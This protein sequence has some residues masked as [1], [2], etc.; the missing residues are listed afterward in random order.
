MDILVL[1]PDTPFEAVKDY[2]LVELRYDL[3]QKEEW[4]TLS[5]RIREINPN[6][7]QIATIRYTTDGG[8]FPITG[9]R[10]KIWNKIFSQKSV[11]EIMDLEFEKID[12]LPMI[13]E[14]WPKVDVIVSKHSFENMPSYETLICFEKQVN[15]S[16]AGGIKL[17]ATSTETK[18][19]DKLYWFA[20]LV[21]PYKYSAAFA[22]NK[23]ETRIK[24][25][26][27]GT[28]L[29]YVFYKDFV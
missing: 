19:L 6:A 4:E 9:N 15:L 26:E 12:F 11:P 1:T 27:E 24:S 20:K 22:M 25:M 14:K 29:N 8:K 28:N 13:R 17:A 16:G 5:A 23:P 7:R 21:K 2:N 18:D 3:F 10:K